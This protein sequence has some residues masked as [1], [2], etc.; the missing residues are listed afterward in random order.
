MDTGE[1]DTVEKWLEKQR[2][3][4]YVEHFKQKGIDD[5]EKVSN[6]TLK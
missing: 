5:L 6:L 3:G 1:V 2:L 4:N